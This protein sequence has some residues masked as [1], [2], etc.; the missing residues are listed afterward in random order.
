MATA[1]LSLILCLGT[2]AL[3]F[4][5]KEIK[6]S[7][8][9]PNQI[10]RNI[11]HDFA[12]VA[13]IVIMS[14]VGNVL[15]KDVKTETLNVPDTFAP[16]YACCTSDCTSNWPSDCEDLSAPYRQRPWIVDLFELNG[17]TWVPYMAAGPALLA[18][19]LVFLDDGITWHLINHPS[20]KLKHGDAY[21]YDTIIIA[22]MIAVNSMLGLPWLVAATV[23]SLNHI[24]AMATKTS[25]GKFMKVRETRL[26]GLGIHLLCLVTIFALSVLKLIPMPIL[27]GI[28][29]YMGLVSLSTNQFWS[30]ILFFFKQP[31]R[32]SDLGESFTHL[33]PMRIHFFTIIQ[34][35]LF[36]ALYFVKAFKAIAIAFPII[37]ALCIPIRLY[38]LPKLFTK[39]ELV[40]LDGDDNAI[41]DCLEKESFDFDH[42]NNHKTN[43]VDLEQINADEESDDGLKKKVVVNGNVN[44][45]VNGNGTDQQQHSTTT[46]PALTPT[47]SIVVEDNNNNNSN[48]EQQQRNPFF[49][50]RPIIT[51]DEEAN[52]TH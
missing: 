41:R 17:H 12:V 36:I 13:S 8:F 24:H 49:S 22:F 15:F 18:F 10:T 30:R 43:N 28:F 51:E 14:L 40:L 9:G 6:F 11:I 50:A 27:Y 5:L 48:G 2:V 42:Q 45:I 38:I 31:S 25:G 16:T 7:P 32:Y 47:D 35:F 29:L 23:R 44:G 3:T 33:R 20:H 34:L 37:I 19:I 21:N 4:W 46:P 26:S 39:D 52:I 1:L